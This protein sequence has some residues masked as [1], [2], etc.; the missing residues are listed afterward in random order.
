MSVV[1]SAA[2]RV[3]GRGRRIRWNVV[4]QALA[5]YLFI[6]P[7]IVELAVFLLGPIVY[8]FVISF[9]HFSY[10][11]PLDSHFVG[12]L[13]YIHLFEDPVFL[14][15]LWNTTVYALVVVPVQTA[16]AMML[17]VIVNRIRGKTIF[18]VIYYLPSITSTVGVAVIFSFLFQPNG[19]LNRLLWILFHIQGPDYFNSPIFAFPAIMAVAVWTTAGQF[20][21]IYL[22]A[23]QEIPEELYEAAAI[24]GAEGFAMLRYITIPSLRRTTFLVVVLGMIGAFQVFDLVYVISSASSLPQQYTMTVV[25]DLFEKGFRTMQMGYASAMGFVLFAIILVLTLIQ[26]L[27]LG[28]EDA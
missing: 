28:R 23:L 22:A 26:Q 17:A 25:L 1:N 27:W 18:R 2:E 7:A 12:F 11:D 5:G 16:I 19:L 13:N 24:D 9:K 21:V 14:R 3:T 20:M 6:L 4:E 8:A 15:A 10:L